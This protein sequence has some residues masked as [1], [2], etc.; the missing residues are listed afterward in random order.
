MEVTGSLALKERHAMSRTIRT[1]ALALLLAVTVVAA[2]ALAAPLGA[3][4]AVAARP[5][6]LFAVLW[7]R[8]A[9][10]FGL[11]G[12]TALW[13]QEGGMMDPNGGSHLTS[14]T[15]PAGSQGA[16]AAWS[17]EGSQM[18]PNG[19]H[20]ST[21]TLPIPPTGEGSSMDPNG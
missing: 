15:P 20:S 7:E 3:R 19:G 11:G 4:P 21:T 16:T 10:L 8:L 9:P 17:Q 6:G 18:D 5:T 12:P 2:T 1:T 13:Q 14:T